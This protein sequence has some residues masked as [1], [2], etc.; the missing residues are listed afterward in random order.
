MS[1]VGPRPYLEEELEEQQG[2]FPGT[3]K[4][5][6][7]MLT[8]KPG[9]TGLWQVNGRSTVSFE[10]RVR[11]EALYSQKISLLID[12]LIIL[13]TPLAVLRAEGAS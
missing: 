5:V 10:E 9:I 3:E 6:K 1:I 13:K 8:V 12:L 2:K 11:M 7:E 4:Y